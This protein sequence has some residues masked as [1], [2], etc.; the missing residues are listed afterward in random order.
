MLLL[1]MSFHLHM[2][3]YILRSFYDRFLRKERDIYIMKWIQNISVTDMMPFPSDSV[4]LQ[5]DVSYD[6]KNARA[7]NAV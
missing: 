2:K 5:C 1:E 7:S 4:A 3:L 6:I